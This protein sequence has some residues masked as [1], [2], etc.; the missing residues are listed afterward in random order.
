MYINKAL[1]LALALTGFT[2]PALAQENY[3]GISVASVNLDV[4]SVAD[5]SP[6]ALFTHFGR[7]I[8]DNFSVELR[9]GS[10]ISDDDISPSDLIDSPELIEAGS[11][12]DVSLNPF[13]G[14]YG[15]GRLPVTSGFSVYGLGGVTYGEVKFETSGGSAEEDDH[16][17]SYGVGARA[18]VTD[19]LS[20]F[21]EYTEY[22]DSTLYQV[23]GA[24]IGAI[25]K[26]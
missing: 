14:A 8:T 26:F 20:G 15:L 9:V 21:A 5:S 12:V 2:T 13:V 18:S 23:S 17:L 3:V 10:G 1:P 22:L 24:S 4:A 19:R 16:S 7:D 25:Y 11:Q 6:T